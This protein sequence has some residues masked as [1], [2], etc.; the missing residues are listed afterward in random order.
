MSYAPTSRQKRR[1]RVKVLL[2]L[3]HKT[4]Y[5]FRVGLSPSLTLLCIAAVLR[6]KGHEPVLIDLN[7]LEPSGSVERTDQ[8]IRTVTKAIERLQPGLV[9]INCFTAARFPFV[10]SLAD[11]IKDKDPDLPIAIGG[12]HPTI[13]SRQ[14]L[15]H[16]PSI[17]A[18]VLGEGERQA[19]ALAEAYDS[20][21]ATRADRL[22]HIDALAYRDVGGRVTCNPR[23]GYLQDLDSLPMPAWDLLDF[24]DYYADHSTW[25]SPRGLTINMSV[26]LYT[27]RSCPFDCVFCSSHHL[28]GRGLRLRSPIRVV[29]EMEMLYNAYGQNYFGFVDDNLTL[30]KKHILAI[31]NEIIRRRMAIQFESAVG[32]NLNSLDEEV[33]GAMAHAGCTYMIMPIEHGNERIRNEIIGKRLSREKI[34]EVASICKQYGLLTSATCIM[35]FPEDTRR[36]LNDTFTLLNEL[37]LDINNVL[38]LIPFPGTRTF[39]QAVQ[40]HLFLEAIDLDSLW[41]GKW[42]MDA[43]ESLF[44]IK[45]Y[46]MNLDELYEFRAKFDTLRFASDR[47]KK[48]Q[49]GIQPETRAVPKR[50]K[51]FSR[52]CSEKT[53]ALLPVE[54][55]K[56]SY[57]RKADHSSEELT[58]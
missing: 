8:C 29:D 37:Q 55:S 15:E 11:A 5:V 14:I 22:R 50:P 34:F 45:P 39:E 7:L 24:E 21:T 35:G 36:T 44:Y 52:G 49:Q 48:L 38:N 43:K 41:K 42:I 53:T 19:V 54:S 40:E 3:P 13:Y 57:G 20:S 46:E 1:Q 27:S 25:Y 18:I 31:C 16:C 12:M 28:M 9:G 56:G 32:Y 33:I 58:L 26:P 6:E 4:E 10:R 2:V 23:K 47:V 51:V 30:N 17:D